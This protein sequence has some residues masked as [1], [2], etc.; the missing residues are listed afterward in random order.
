MNV[1]CFEVDNGQLKQCRV[2]FFIADR[3]GTCR[4]VEISEV[5]SM[6]P[7]KAV[8]EKYGVLA[9]VNKLA[10]IGY[11]L[12]TYSS[13][14]IQS[15]DAGS[16]HDLKGFCVRLAQHNQNDVVSLS[17]TLEVSRFFIIGKL[18]SHIYFFCQHLITG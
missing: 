13:L 10:T 15:I 9:C 1:E 4:V 8:T 3:R 16:Y 14:K 11:N 7:N 5:E 17:P 12:P 2:S 6:A 18:G